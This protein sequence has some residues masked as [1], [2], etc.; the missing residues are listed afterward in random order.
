MPLQGFVPTVT[1]AVTVLVLAS[2]LEME[3]LGPF[4]TQTALGEA[5][6]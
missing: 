1:V 4:E 3:F 2:S 6:V 5:M